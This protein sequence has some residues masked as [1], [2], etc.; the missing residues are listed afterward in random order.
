MHRLHLTEIFE[1]SGIDAVYSVVRDLVEVDPLII[2][3]PCP[4]STD[5]KNDACETV[6]TRVQ[7]FGNVLFEKTAMQERPKEVHIVEVEPR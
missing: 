6:V 3:V 1:A 2:R 4:A 5:E 7:A